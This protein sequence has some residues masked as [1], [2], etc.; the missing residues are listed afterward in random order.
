[1]HVSCWLFHFVVCLYIQWAGINIQGVWWPIN[2]IAHS[3]FSEDV[4]LYFNR[5]LM[6]LHHIYLGIYTFI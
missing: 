1:M 4:F 6:C 2:A 3:T 5:S